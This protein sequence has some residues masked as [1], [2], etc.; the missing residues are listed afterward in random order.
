MKLWLS[1]RVPARDEVLLPCAHG[2]K[3]LAGELKIK[4]FKILFDASRVD[5]FGNG[6]PPVLK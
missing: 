2:G 1:S 5:G 4:D 3:I 6:D